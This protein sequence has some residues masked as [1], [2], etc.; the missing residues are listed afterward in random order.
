MVN[1]VVYPGSEPIT[2]EWGQIIL[3][4]LTPVHRRMIG[5]MELMRLRHNPFIK[6]IAYPRDKEKFTHKIYTGRGGMAL[7]KSILN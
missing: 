2:D 4:K 1:Y 5:I 6:T 7:W 3:Y